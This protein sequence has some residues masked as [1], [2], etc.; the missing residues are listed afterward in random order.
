MIEVVAET[1][2]GNE[3]LDAMAYLDAAE[4]ELAARVTGKP[5]SYSIKDRSLT[6]ASVSELK[7]IIKYWT[8][9]IT[10]LKAADARRKG[11]VSRKITHTRF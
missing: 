6:R 11:G 10:S 8:A 3:L 4:V 7:S 9:K 5:S 1:A 2:T